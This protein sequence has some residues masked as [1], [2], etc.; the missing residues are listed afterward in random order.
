MFFY[1]LEFAILFS[2]PGEILSKIYPPLMLGTD[3]LAMIR[4]FHLYLIHTHRMLFLTDLISL[5][6]VVDRDFVN[7][8]TI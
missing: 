8:S 3:G 2:V 5:P 6:G 1:L 4:I 7:T